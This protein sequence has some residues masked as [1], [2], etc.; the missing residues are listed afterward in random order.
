MAH[1][2]V[3]LDSIPATFKLFS[4]EPAVLKFVRRL[5]PKKNNKE[6]IRYASIIVLNERSIKTKIKQIQPS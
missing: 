5:S 3:V 1:D 6:E 4:R 2:R